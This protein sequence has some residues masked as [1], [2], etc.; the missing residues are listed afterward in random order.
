MPLLPGV[1]LF[2]TLVFLANITQKRNEPALRRL[3]TW[4]FVALNLL[5]FIAGL[6]L[7]FFRPG[8]LPD[9]ALQ[10]TLSDLDLRPAGV[11]LLG[12]AI[13]GLLVILPELR[14]WLSRWSALD[15]DSPVHTLALMFSGYLVGNT[16]ITLT[17]GGLENL[18]E[19]AT[20]TSILEVV[21]SQLLFAL[22][23]I[24]GVGVLVRRDGVKLLERLGLAMPTP[25]QLLRGAGWVLLLFMLQTVAAGLWQQLNPE[26]VEL[27]ENINSQLLGG[28]DTVWEWF[29]LALAAAVGEELLFR[30]ALQPVFG[31]WPTALLFAVA[32]IQYGLTPATAFLFVVGLVLG[33]LRRRYNT[34]VA[35]F[36]HFGYDFALGVLVL[37]APYMEQL[38]EQMPQ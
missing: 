18:A 17:Q 37:L 11:I 36:V 30:G 3:T 2:F 19:T 31:L 34:G 27:L 33:Y 24:T 26:E 8:Q 13:W 12:M 10:S 7:L 4:L 38:L 28:F 21:A 6:L 16:L 9:D 23:G 29:L 25:R 14:Q 1:I 15:P 20:A 32:H 22:A 35:I 5:I